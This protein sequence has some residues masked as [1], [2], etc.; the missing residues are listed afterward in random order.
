MGRLKKCPPPYTL[1]L[2]PPKAGMCLPMENH[3]SRP[4]NCGKY[5]KKQGAVTNR[6]VS[7]SQNVYL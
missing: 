6:K 2:T 1:K 5:D 3:C 4:Q 7:Y